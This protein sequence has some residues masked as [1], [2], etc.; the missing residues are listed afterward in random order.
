VDDV[1]LNVL[2]SF[3]QIADYTGIGGNLNV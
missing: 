1:V 2:D 3:N